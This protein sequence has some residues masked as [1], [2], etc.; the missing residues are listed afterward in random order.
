MSE[1]TRLQMLEEMLAAEP[2]DSF[3]NYGLAMEYLAAG[4]AE[5]AVARLRHLT[6]TVNPSYSAGYYQLGKALD[7]L[8]RVDE[9]KEV[10]TRGIAIAEKS[11]DWH[12]AGEMKEL[13][14][15][16]E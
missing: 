9:A 3:V 13:L 14:A 2:N 6:G 5:D 8:N 15:S 12:T 16:L 11:G 1:K 4:R 10:L 7:G